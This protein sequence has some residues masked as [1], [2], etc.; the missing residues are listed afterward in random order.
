MSNLQIIKRNGNTVTFEDDKIKNA[1]RNAMK[2]TPAGINEDLINSITTKI[3]EHA[4]SL[5]FA[6]EVDNIQDLVE[7]LLMA[8]DRRDAAK[9]YIVYRYERDKKRN[10]K[11][12]EKSGLLSDE[13]ISKYKHIEPPMTELGKFVYLRTYSRYLPE[14][15]RREYWWE[16]VRRAVEYNCSLAPTGKEEAEKLYDNIFNLRQFLSGRTFWVGG[17]KVAYSF[18]SGNFNCAFEII[19]NFDAFGDLFYLLMVGA[20]VGVRILKDDVAKLPKVRTNFKLI[21]EDY[22]PL[23]KS[24][25]E[26]NTSLTFA[27]NDTATITIGDSKEGWVESLNFFF[28]LVANP[29]Y[30]E[31]NTIIVNYNNVRPKGEPLKTFGG[32]ASGHGSIKNMFTK[33]LNVIQKQSIMGSKIKLKPIDCMDIVNIIGENVVVG[34]VR[35]TSE[36]VLIDSDDHDCINA[37]KNLYIQENGKWV[38]NKEIIHR[39]MSNNS[40]YY[41]QRPTREQLHWHIEQMR[42]SGEPGW[43]NAEAASKRRPNMNGV[44]PCGEILL[45]S[46]GLCN[47]TTLNTMA[48]V[49]PTGEID[50]EALYE[51]QK[52]SARAA[53]RMTCIELELNEWNNV[54]QRDKLLGCSLTGWQDMVNATKINSSQEAALLY[55]MRN[56]AHDESEKYA[57]QIGE[58]VPLLVTTVKP[59]GT[60]SQLPTVSSGVHYAHAPYYIRRVRINAHDPIVKVCKELNYSIFP[61]VG[62]VMETASTVVLEFPCKAPEGVTKYDVSAIQQLENYKMFM[63]HYVDHNCSITVHVRE[64]EWEGVEQWVWDNWDICVAL[65]FLSLD[66][67]FYQLMPYEAI[68]EEEYNKRISEMRPFSTSLL[69]KYETY[70][71]ELDIGTDG[72]DAGI[73]PIK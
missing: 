36:V 15:N 72:C 7:D 24:K 6:L 54:Q 44:N 29:S 30:K 50:T 5:S 11:K 64:N 16:T 13:F 37:K 49:T 73:C 55:N 45:D 26:N 34:G 21:N 67:T 31:V 38:P 46:K 61:E 58:N 23:A 42:F 19:D 14:E 17:T 20:G 18:P 32:T 10:T 41:K 70:E 57:K 12:E 9:T 63:A 8:S 43:V 51:A 62:Q 33:I 52:L 48:F 1:I 39:S 22:S 68:T 25:R 60:L 53:Y 3:H 40:I 66:D 69:S 71:T 56:I 4:E 47:L 27:H 59:E 65:T 35:R 2:E 28:E